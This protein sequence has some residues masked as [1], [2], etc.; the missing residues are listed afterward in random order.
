MAFKIGAASGTYKWPV[1]VTIPDNGKHTTEQFTAIFNRL[2]HD[3][4]MEIIGAMNRFSKDE[5]RD[6]DPT[7]VEACAEVL[8]GWED[9]TGP[10]DKP[11]PFT[12]ANMETM[13][14]VEF[15]PFQLLTAWAES[16][17]E[18]KRKN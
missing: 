10:D 16:K 5:R 4:C 3:R 13:L 18:G 11:L 1:K 14:S 2:E 7:E 6:D 12:P 15:L 9:V 8:A 17:N